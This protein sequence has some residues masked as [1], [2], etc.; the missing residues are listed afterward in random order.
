MGAGAAGQ[1]E[2]MPSN[3]LPA[4]HPAERS[5]SPASSWGKI[6]HQS[7]SVRSER[8]SNVL[9]LAQH[10]GSLQRFMLQLLPTAF[11]QPVSCSEAAP[12]PEK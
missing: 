12:S 7:A 3:V 6:G 8:K 5:P 1:G 2:Q 9:R 11:L 10:G 4:P